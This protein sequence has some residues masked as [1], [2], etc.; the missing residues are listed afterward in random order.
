[1]DPSAFDTKGIKG[2]GKGRREKQC[3]N[4]WNFHNYCSKK[5]KTG[6]GKNQVTGFKIL[7]DHKEKTKI[8]ILMGNYKG[9]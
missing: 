6:C 9:T 1:M 4:L 3:K 2:H 7:T 5:D 8:Y